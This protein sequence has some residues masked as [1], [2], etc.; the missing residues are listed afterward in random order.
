MSLL[1]DATPG[2]K[3]QGSE[4]TFALSILVTP[5][6]KHTTP[7]TVRTAAV[8]AV[9]HRERSYLRLRVDLQ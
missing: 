4:G 7:L 8:H 6:R 3:T 5:A 2:R 1:C 9:Q